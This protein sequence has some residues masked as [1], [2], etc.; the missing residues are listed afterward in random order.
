MKP[1]PKNILELYFIILVIWN[2]SIQRIIEQGLLATIK[3]HIFLKIM[4]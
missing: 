2:P 4:E 3:E 1:A